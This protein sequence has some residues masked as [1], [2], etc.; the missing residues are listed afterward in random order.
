MEWLFDSSAMGQER[1]RQW[2]SFNGVPKGTERRRYQRVYLEL[3]VQY[4]LFKA[5]FLLGKKTKSVNIS[6]CGLLCPVPY[7]VAESSLVEL[8]IL[9]PGSPVRTVG[10]VMWQR[11]AKGLGMPHQGVRFLR[12]QDEDRKKI[13]NYIYA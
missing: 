3:P 6:T 13:A 2:R 8:E 5:D 11:E 12:I 1:R 10:K 9:L 7:L 4:S